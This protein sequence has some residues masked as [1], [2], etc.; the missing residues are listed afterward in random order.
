MATL[1]D[2][3]LT[4]THEKEYSRALLDCREEGSLGAVQILE[5]LVERLKSFAALNALLEGWQVALK[6]ILKQKSPARADQAVLERFRS[7]DY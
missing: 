4:Y 7:F 5:T 3:A 1:V 2:A 6:A